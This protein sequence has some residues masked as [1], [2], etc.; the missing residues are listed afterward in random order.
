MYLMLIMLQIE[1]ISKNNTYKQKSTQM[2]DS[3]SDPP[4]REHQGIVS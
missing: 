3:G 4:V 1:F 2:I